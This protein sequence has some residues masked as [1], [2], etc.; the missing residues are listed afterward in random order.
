VQR[1]VQCHGACRRP[2]RAQQVRCACRAAVVMCATG[3][4]MTQRDCSRP[5]WCP[6]SPCIC[7]QY[8]CARVCLC[9]SRVLIACTRAQLQHGWEFSL[10]SAVHSGGV[11][12]RYLVCVCV[13]ACDRTYHIDTY[14]RVCCDR[15]CAIR[16][17]AT[18][19]SSRWWRASSKHSCAKTWC[20]NTLSVRCCCDVVRAA[21]YSEEGTAAT[22]G[23]A[24]T[25]ASCNA[26]ARMCVCV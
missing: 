22:R 12:L 18:R 23:P 3:R 20:V 19:Y 4:S 21:R 9:R 17:C 14:E 25:G 16:H 15:T 26:R 7:R 1:R 13:R 6:R 11:N 24:T 8:A 10:Q 5:R 2:R